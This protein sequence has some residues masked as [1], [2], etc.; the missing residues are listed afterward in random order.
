VENGIWRLPGEYL[1]EDYLIQASH[2]LA[3]EIITT[4]QPH[5]SFLA[6]GLG[7]EIPVHLPA[8]QHYLE[9]LVNYI[10]RHGTIFKYLSPL[11]YNRIPATLPIDFCLINKYDQSIFTLLKPGSA[12]NPVLSGSIPLVLGNVG[13]S[14]PPAGDEE[15]TRQNENQISCAQR[16][17][18]LYRPY[19]AKTGFIWESFQDW[20]AAIPVS[21]GQ[22]VAPTEWMYTYG[23]ISWRGEKRDLYQK[24]PAFMNY[25]FSEI[26]E[27]PAT[28]KT[29]NFFSFSTFICS[30]IF[31]LFY[32]RNYR[33]KENIKRSLAHPYGFYVDLRDR[34]IIS[35][36]NSTV[37]GIFSNLMVAMLLAALVFYYRH[38]IFFEEVAST[39]IVPLGIKENYLSILRNPLS[40]LVFILCW[41]YLSQYLVALFLRVMNFFT[42]AKTRF[43][44]LVAM[45]NWAGAPLILLL[46]LSM[47]SLHLLPYA[48][49]A[50]LFFYVLVIFFFWY[51]YRLGS[52]IRVFFI[53]RPY[54]VI[55]LL[56]LIYAI[57]ISIF[58]FLNGRNY[59]LLDYLSLLTEAK[60]LF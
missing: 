18:K 22:K 11:D 52:G 28:A 41:L 45:C 40:I 53:M 4:F 57:P 34:R 7:Q 49:V 55:L 2:V 3:E 59:S 9:S 26:Y 43:R 14:A 42:E 44:Q 48:H 13:F 36:V 30:L 17:F 32:Q 5:P 10:D 51:N 46:P 8:A 12:F 31:L 35:I 38:D 50:A 39:L 21:V 33:F 6:F 25:E 1:A 37:I 56:L 16:F 58:L 27:N 47:F 23:L 60:N 20:P 29:S 19:A 15:Y 54:K 24:L